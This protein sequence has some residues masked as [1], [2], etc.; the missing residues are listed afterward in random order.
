MKGNTEQKIF[1]VTDS[2]FKPK[3]DKGDFVICEKNKLPPVK[4]RRWNATE[5]KAAAVGYITPYVPTYIE[6]V[7]GVGDV[8]VPEI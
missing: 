4:G 1:R 7:K 3:A 6:Y 8:L 5:I 2:S